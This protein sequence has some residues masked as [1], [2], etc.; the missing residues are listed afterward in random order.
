MSVD[1]DFKNKMIIRYASLLRR[2][3]DSNPDIGMGPF[4]WTLVDEALKDLDID[5]SEIDY[6]YIINNVRI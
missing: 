1:R 3:H 6:D 5:K 4:R 2:Y